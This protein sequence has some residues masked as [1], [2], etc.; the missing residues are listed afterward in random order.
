MYL[1]GPDIQMKEEKIT[2]G[3]ILY[4]KEGKLGQGAGDLK[5]N[6]DKQQLRFRFQSFRVHR[7]EPF[8]PFTFFSLSMLKK[9]TV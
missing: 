3:R 7:L 9:Y 2:I 8:S 6:R 1:W 4:V 5:I